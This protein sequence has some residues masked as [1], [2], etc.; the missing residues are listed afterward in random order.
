M[1]VI[2]KRTNA[3]NELK[4]LI[5]SDKDIIAVHYSHASFQNITDEI[6]P[7]IT[8]IIV[9]SL[10]GNIYE[11]FGIHIEADLI[12]LTR[13]DIKDYYPELELSMLEKFNDFM[14]RHNNCYWL[15]WDM[16]N[17]N[18]GFQAIRHRYAKLAG[19]KKVKDFIEIPSHQKINLNTILSEMYGSKYASSSDKLLAMIN[20]NDMDKTRYITLSAEESEF[21]N[22]NFKVISDSVDSKVNAIVSLFNALINKKIKIPNK[23]S[24]SIFLDVITHPLFHLIGWIATILGVVITVS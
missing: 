13:Q 17:I 8:S 7:M 14:K 10:T 19:E 9:R 22:L 16:I 21:N 3:R 5:N 23:N 2:Q 12:N 1:G 20:N 18:F 15:H 6:S 11:Y 4:N 24:Y